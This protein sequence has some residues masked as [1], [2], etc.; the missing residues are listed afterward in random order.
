MKVSLP[1]WNCVFSILNNFLTPGESLEWNSTKVVENNSRPVFQWE[2]FGNSGIISWTVLPPIETKDT[3]SVIT[4][5]LFTRALLKV[6][7]CQEDNYN[8]QLHWPC[9][10]AAD[11]YMPQ[12]RREITTQFN[13]GTE[14]TDRR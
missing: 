2:Y 11:I 5:Y 6:D 14:N 7:R 13:L 3:S 12:S 8:S 1:L 10:W 4:T 9:H